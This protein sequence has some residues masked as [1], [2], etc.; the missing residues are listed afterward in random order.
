MSTTCSESRYVPLLPLRTM[1]VPCRSKHGTR[2]LPFQRQLTSSRNGSWKSSQ[3]RLGSHGPCA[4]QVGLPCLQLRS[5]SKVILRRRPICWTLFFELRSMHGSAQGAFSWYTLALLVLIFRGLVRQ[6]MA[7]RL[8]CAQM[9]SFRG[10]LA[11][12]LTM[13]KKFA[14]APWS[15]TL[16]LSSAGRS[17]LQGD[18]GLSKTQTHQCS[19]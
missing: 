13:P 2:Y 5:T 1:A 11:W 19:G 18:T 12:I 15:S 10:F 16:L 7:V 14:W 4:K 6:G 8:L 17:L 3:G 9:T